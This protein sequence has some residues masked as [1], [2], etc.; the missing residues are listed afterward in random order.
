ML[1]FVLVFSLHIENLPTSYS[2]FLFSN[3]LISLDTFLEILFRYV[4]LELEI[5]VKQILIR[6]SVLQT[7]LKRNTDT[8]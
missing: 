8:S 4:L 7:D 2:P 6:Y 3:F 1:V 5:F